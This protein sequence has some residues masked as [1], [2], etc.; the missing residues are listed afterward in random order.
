MTRPED[1]MGL[2]AGFL[3]SPLR[4]TIGEQHTDGYAHSVVERVNTTRFG[5]DPSR[6]W[7]RS[8]D[9]FD[10]W[11]TGETHQALVRAGYTWNGNS[12][13][14]VDA[15][16]YAEARRR[17]SRAAFEYMYHFSR[18]EPETSWSLAPFLYDAQTHESGP[19]SDFRRFRPCNLDNGYKKL[20][21]IHRRKSIGIDFTDY[22]PNSND[23][24]REVAGYAGFREIV[25]TSGFS[26]AHIDFSIDG[27]ALLFSADENN[28]R[29][30]GPRLRELVARVRPVAEHE[31]VVELAEAYF[32][33]VAPRFR[34]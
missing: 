23:V 25:Y 8:K 28:D 13:E 12:F 9:Y 16:I 3:M 5:E 11:I 6:S 34:S 19:V 31:F 30:C 26:D 18:K 10:E 15:G 33:A 24:A 2:K 7:A 4:W 32:G 1:I 22:D 20:G 27:P 14:G 17:V 29:Q 21:P